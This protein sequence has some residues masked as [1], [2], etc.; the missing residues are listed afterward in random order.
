M[1]FTRAGAV[2]RRMTGRDNWTETLVGPT[3]RKTG[4]VK[5]SQ[6]NGRAFHEGDQD[7][8]VDLVPI[9]FKVVLTEFGVAFTAIL[10]APL[11]ITHD[12]PQT[13][14]RALSR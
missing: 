5:F 9:G 7:V 6:A 14:R 8:R 2:I 3:C 10:A 4:S 13:H 11:R 12:P 1:R